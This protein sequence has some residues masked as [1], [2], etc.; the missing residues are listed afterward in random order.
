MSGLLDQRDLFDKCC[1]HV[2]QYLQTFDECSS[3]D[4]T[5]GFKASQFDFE[6]WEKKNIP[7]KLS[8]DLKGF[9]SMFNGFD[10]SFSVDVAGSN[11]SI[12]TMH[13]NNL[14]DI[15]RQPLEGIFPFIDDIPSMTSA[16]F[17]LDDSPKEGNIC[18]VYRSPEDCEKMLA[19]SGN[20]TAVSKTAITA[21]LHHSNSRDNT[22]IFLRAKSVSSTKG[23]KKNPDEANGYVNPEIWFQDRSS[24]WHYVAQSFSDFMRLMIVHVGIEG[25]HLAFTP[26]GLPPACKQWMGLFCKERLTIDMHQ[27]E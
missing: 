16:A 25:W 24:R 1:L 22:E 13:L 7:Y 23:G 5:S 26:E 27:K 19:C 20:N 14:D 2:I 3:V 6:K 10:F 15:E 18:L 21:T 9:Y 12:G 8:D 17:I 11:I 4:F